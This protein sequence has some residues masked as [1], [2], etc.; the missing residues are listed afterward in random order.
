[1]N[2]VLLS[3]FFVLFL[4]SCSR[5]DEKSKKD[6]K[7][8]VVQLDIL[9]DSNTVKTF[10]SSCRT[11]RHDCN[12]EELNNQLE[13]RV[14]PQGYLCNFDHTLYKVDD[15]GQNKLVHNYTCKTSVYYIGN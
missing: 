5:V 6:Y 11:Y 3:L 8:I 7:Q 10:K 12:F 2:K 4:S 9:Q 15:Y 1:M 13:T 14:F